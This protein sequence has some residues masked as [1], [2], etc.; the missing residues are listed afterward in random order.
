LKKNGVLRYHAGAAGCFAAL[1]LIAISL[2]CLAQLPGRTTQDPVLE[3]RPQQRLEL[4][5]LARPAPEFRVGGK[6]R[7]SGFRVTGL[8]AI[9]P[10]E[11]RPVLEPWTGRE[12]A[13]EDFDRLLDDVSRYLRDRGLLV[14]TAYLPAQS[15]DGG[16]VEIAVLEGRVG[17]YRLDL[18]PDA[19]LKRR[20]AEGFL[21]RLGPGAP[22]RSGMFDTPLLLL[23]DLPGARVEPVLT[24]G[25]SPGTADLVVRASDEPLVAGFVSFDNHEIDEVGRY[26]GTAHL[27]LRNL[28][29]IGDLITGEFRSTYTGDLARAT[30]TYSIPVNHEGT[31]VAALASAQS[32]RLKGDIEALGANSNYTRGVLAVTHPFLRTHDSNIYSYVALNRIYDRD[33]L[34]LFATL[35]RTRHS[36]VTTR[37]HADR[38]DQWLGGGR[39][40]MYW[41][42]QAGRI[43]VENPLLDPLG[44]D[45]DYSRWRTRVERLQRVSADGELVASFFLQGASQN[46]APGREFEIGGPYGVRA[47]PAGEMYPDEGYLGKV[48]YNHLLYSTNGWS[49]AGGLFWDTA[50][51]KLNKDPLPGAVDNARTF[52]GMGTRLMIGRP[53]VF[54]AAITLAWRTTRAAETDRDLHPRVWFTAAAY[55]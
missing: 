5:P 40:G 20:T 51:G 10:A 27:R 24:P 33:R 2:P 6:V 13:A 7:V 9:D 52:S 31:R 36:Y 37:L 21:S 22:I 12:L 3:T 32:S 14:A 54:D 29:G 26:A 41:E 44:V 43:D 55:F 28:A 4:H 47:Y 53:G 35:I 23:N 45:G 49:V 8:T 16:T 17:S 50:R 30:L 39:I 34:D 25:S 48:D 46:L 1:A 42:Y 11:L 38:T 15:L 18:G 19:R